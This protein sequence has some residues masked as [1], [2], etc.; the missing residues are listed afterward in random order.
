MKLT[1]MHFKRYISVTV[2]A[3]VMLLFAQTLQAQ[4]APRTKSRKVIKRTAYVLDRTRDAVRSHQVYTGKLAHARN[5]QLFA[6][7]L[8][9]NQRFVRAIN[10]S[11]HAR[12][13][14]FEAMKAN[15]TAPPAGL[16]T[17]PGLPEN[18]PS[19][20]DLEF[21]LD[22]EFDGKLHNDMQ[23]AESAEAYDLEIG[24]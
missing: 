12:R 24:E 23:A 16:D 13:L 1:L 15:K 22:T 21:E 19:E 9:R 3:L 8:H 11:M 6:F 5:H 14:A 17:E 18:P 2:G 7:Q 4:Q 10:H 20:Q